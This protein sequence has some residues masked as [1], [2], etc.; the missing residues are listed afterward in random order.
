MSA[1]IILNE[2]NIILIML[3][4][5]WMTAVFKISLGGEELSYHNLLIFS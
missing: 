5:L 4:S 2:R 3:D 1:I